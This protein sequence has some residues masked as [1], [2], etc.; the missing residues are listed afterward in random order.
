[1]GGAG[2]RD[3]AIHEIT[4]EGIIRPQG[5]SAYGKDVNVPVEHER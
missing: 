2:S 3:R 1:M 4:G 5:A